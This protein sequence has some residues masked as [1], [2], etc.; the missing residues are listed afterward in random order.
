MVTQVENATE[1]IQRDYATRVERTLNR[2][3]K[4]E[5]NKPKIKFNSVEP[6]HDIEKTKL[7]DCNKLQQLFDR[8][9]DMKKDI[10]EAVDES[11]ELIADSGQTVV[12]LKSNGFSIIGAPKGK[13]TVLS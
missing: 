11:E 13:K 5:G 10:R 9:E 12:G 6:R 3:Y 8:C 1:L 4:K 2:L 7:N